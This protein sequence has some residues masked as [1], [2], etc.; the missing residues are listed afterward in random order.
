[1]AATVMWVFA[2]AFAVLA[3]VLAALGLYGVLSYIV[4]Q[5]TLEIGIRVALGAQRWNILSLV[6]GEGMRLVIGGM[7]I[8]M[9]IAIAV[10]RLIEQ[11]L[12]GMSGRDPVVFLSVPVV[13]T[14]VAL[15]ACYIPVWRSDAHRSNPRS[16]RRMKKRP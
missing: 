1:V 2:A 8:G 9:I 5:R 12:Y 16:T 3:L 10:S 11:L 15:L 13:L 7:V 6:C 4:K 14:A